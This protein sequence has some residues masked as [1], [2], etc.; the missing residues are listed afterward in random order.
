MYVCMYIYIY[1]YVYLCRRTKTRVFKSLVLP[2]LRYGCDTWT[3]SSD[4]ERRPMSL[5]TSAF[6]ESWGI[7]G[8]TLCQASDYSMK[9]I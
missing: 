4:L 3:L 5:V 8:M 2:V 7:A 6:A 9:L 1:T